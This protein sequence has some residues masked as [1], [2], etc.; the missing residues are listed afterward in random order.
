[1]LKADKNTLKANNRQLILS[2]LRRREQSRSELAETTGLSKST[3]SGLV[4][5]LLSKNIVYE[6][7]RAASSGGR[8]PV[9]LALEPRC[10]YTLVIEA[11]PHKVEASLVGLDLAV[12]DS[13]T[14]NYETL[15]AESFEEALRLTVRSFLSRPG[16]AVKIVG[17]AAAVPGAIDYADGTLLYSSHLG[18]H[19]FKISDIIRSELGK[20]VYIFKDTEAMLLGEYIS[21]GLDPNGSYVYIVVRNG[22]GM[23][24][25]RRGEVLHFRRSGLELGHIKL[26]SSGPQC[27]CGKYGCAESFVSASAARRDLKVLLKASGISDT[28]RYDGLGLDDIVRLSNSG[29]PY[30]RR[31]LSEQCRHLGKAAAFAV[32]MFAPDLVLIGGPLAYTKWDILSIIRTSMAEHTIERYGECGIALAV[33]DKASYIAGMADRVF[34]REFF[35]ASSIG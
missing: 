24:Y 12:A 9:V 13:I 17:A 20:P 23:S 27:S 16:V 19:D 35:G 11:G 34:G 10:S 29:D 3:V 6:K 30:C 8:R 18:V 31:V 22:L 2:T 26:E 15:G 21:G 28:G 4:Q 32:N 33:S 7:E 5:E 14:E 1:M 25:M